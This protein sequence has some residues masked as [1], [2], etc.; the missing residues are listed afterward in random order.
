MLFKILLL[1]A[2]GAV[3]G[4]VAPGGLVGRRGAVIQS[5]LL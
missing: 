4:A 1:G 5:D 3:F 2:L